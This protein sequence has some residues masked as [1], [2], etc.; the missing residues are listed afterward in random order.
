MLKLYKNDNIRCL[1]DDIDLQPNSN[2]TFITDRQKVI[3]LAIKTV[4]SSAEHKIFLR[5]IHE[6]IKHEWCGQA[7]KDL[8]WRSTS[9]TTV[10]D[11][12]KCRPK[13]KRKRSKHKDEPFLKDDKLRKKGRMITCQSCGNIRHN[14]ATCKGQGQKSTTGGNNAEA[15]GLSDAGGQDGSGGVSVGVGSQSSSHTR[16]TKRRNADGKE[17]GD[18]IPTQSSATGGASEWSI[19]NCKKVT[20]LAEEI[21]VLTLQKKKANL[22]KG[23]FMMLVEDDMDWYTDEIRE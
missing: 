14:K 15:N 8:L 22:D 10:R 13:K 23:K 18:G 19:M 11:F 2:F 12:E 21:M 4:F 16:W 9:A 17:M 5:H 3:I 7:Y 20:P 1:G 6:N